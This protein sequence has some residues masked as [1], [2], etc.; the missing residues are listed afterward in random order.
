MW[1][2]SLDSIAIVASLQTTADDWRWHRH[3]WWRER[4][5]A[6]GH[7]NVGFDDWRMAGGWYVT[8]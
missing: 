7:G 3:D 2:F 1:W 5:T 8:P 6:D 4:Y